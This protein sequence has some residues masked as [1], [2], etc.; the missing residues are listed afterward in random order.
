MKKKILIICLS[1]ILLGAILFIPIPIGQSK[2][3]GTRV[4]SALTY[5]VVVWSRFTDETDKEGQLIKYCNTS[6][7]W[8]PDNKKSIDELWEM[9]TAE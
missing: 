6:V 9:E 8:Y 2:D 4:Y 3:G 5:K 1:A 7:F